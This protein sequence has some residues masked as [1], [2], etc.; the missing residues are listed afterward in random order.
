[1]NS[2]AEPTPLEQKKRAHLVIRIVGLVALVGAVVL[3][4]NNLPLL[5]AVAGVV[6]LLVVTSFYLVEVQYSK[7]L[8]G[9][10]NERA[11]MSAR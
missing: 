1:M 5:G 6:V 7:A 8:A 9:A 2:S 3:L 4:W 10:L 11:A